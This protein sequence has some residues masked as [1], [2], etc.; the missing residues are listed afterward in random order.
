[1]CLSVYAAFDLA[2]RLSFHFITEKLKVTTK[3]VY[4]FGIIAAGIF[5]SI[6]AESRTFK[7]VLF[8]IAIFGYIRATS[9]VNQVLILSDHCTEHYPEKFS[10]AYGLNMIIKGIVVMILGQILGHLRDVAISYETC[11][12]LHNAFLVIILLIW[13]IQSKCCKR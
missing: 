4:I 6:F 10:G 2:S 13:S 7:T 11:F 8:S 12:H 9:V 3:G 5:R 1:M